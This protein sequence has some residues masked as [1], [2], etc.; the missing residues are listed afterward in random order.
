MHKKN[1]EVY[2]QGWLI[3]SPP[4]RRGIFKLVSDTFI[5]FQEAPTIILAHGSQRK[6]LHIALIH[7]S[8]L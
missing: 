3:K 6:P 5:A 8:S 4:D 1:V 2:H 7:P